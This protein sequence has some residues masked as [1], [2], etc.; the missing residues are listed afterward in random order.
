MQKG[1][2]SCLNPTFYAN[3][4][5]FLLQACGQIGDYCFAIQILVGVRLMRI[6]KERCVVR[7]Q[8]FNNCA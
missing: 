4:S 5:V 7:A 2:L 8:R 3:F 6:L 1:E